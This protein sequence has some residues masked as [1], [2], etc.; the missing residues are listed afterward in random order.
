M[1]DLKSTKATSCIAKCRSWRLLGLGAIGEETGL[2]E[3]VG[4]GK[5]L[6]G[7]DQGRTRIYGGTSAPH[8]GEGGDCLS[9]E[10]RYHGSDQL[11]ECGVGT[12]QDGTRR[13]G[14][15]TA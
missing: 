2:Q 4:K 9:T 5:H 1:S 6:V 3:T 10:G 7:H 14:G 13:P 11:A 8:R 12:L 15:I